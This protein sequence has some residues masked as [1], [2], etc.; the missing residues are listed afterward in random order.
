[1]PFEAILTVVPL[2]AVIGL[3]A[4]ALYIVYAVAS[5]AGARMR[6]LGCPSA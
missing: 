1:M 2:V 3:G 4:V 5:C 6:D